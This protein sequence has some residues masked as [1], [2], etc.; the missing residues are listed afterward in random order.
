M[1]RLSPFAEPV[2]LLSNDTTVFRDYSLL[3]AG[4]TVDVSI[5]LATLS[6]DLFEE[7]ELSSGPAGTDTM[8]QAVGPYLNVLAY[9]VN[10]GITCAIAESIDL[11]G[12]APIWFPF[13]EFQLQPAQPFRVPGW[14]IVGHYA[15]VRMTNTNA[16]G[17]AAVYWMVKMSTI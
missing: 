13:P 4:Q 6:E 8:Q 5:D 1:S 16:S 12:A 9:T 3:S 2:R 10:G 7:P 17:L 14:R 15:R 11:P